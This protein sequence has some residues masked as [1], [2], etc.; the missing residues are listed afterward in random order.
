M[1]AGLVFGAAL[2]VL[3][4][5]VAVPAFGLSGKPTEVPVSSHLYGL[6]AHLVYG[7]SAEIARRGMRAALG[8][9]EFAMGQEPYTDDI[10]ASGREAEH[11]FSQGA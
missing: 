11:S 7:I 10:R 5:E 9:G 4:D 6:G 3:A 8:S 2:F 1:V